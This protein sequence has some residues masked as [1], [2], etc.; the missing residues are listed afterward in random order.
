MKHKVIIQALAGLYFLGLINSFLQ[1]FFDFSF[2]PAFFYMSLFSILI[3][4]FIL[5]SKLKPKMKALEAKKHH[6]HY[7]KRRLLLGINIFLVFR[8]IDFSK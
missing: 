1:L 3:L 6:K 8:D 5:Y 4:F 7:S 2:N